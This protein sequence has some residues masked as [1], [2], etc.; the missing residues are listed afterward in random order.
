MRHRAVCVSPPAMRSVLR[1]MSWDCSPRQIMTFRLELQSSA[2]S[3]PSGLLPQSLSDVPSNTDRCLHQSEISI[4]AANWIQ[5][6]PRERGECGVANDM[7]D[8][9]PLALRVRSGR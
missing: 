3:P 7:G 1:A 6:Y 8:D 9:D 5:P 2:Y 4:E